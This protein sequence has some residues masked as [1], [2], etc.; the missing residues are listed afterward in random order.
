MLRW[1]RR[2]FD[3][4]TKRHLVCFNPAAAFDLTGKVKAP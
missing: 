2:M 4:A 1:V 3:D